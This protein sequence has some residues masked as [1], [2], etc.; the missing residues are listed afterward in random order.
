M[1]TRL[2]VP[3]DRFQRFEAALAYQSL[4][5]MRWLKALF[6]EWLRRTIDSPN[7]SATLKRRWRAFPE[8]WWALQREGWSVRAR[9][10]L[11]ASLPG[12]SQ[13][14]E[15]A[16]RLMVDR[17]LDTRDIPFPF[18]IFQ[19]NIGSVCK[20]LLHDPVVWEH[21]SR[22]ARTIA[23]CVRHAFIMLASCFWH[24]KDVANIQPLAVL[25]ARVRE[26]GNEAREALRVRRVRPEWVRLHQERQ[27]AE[28]QRDR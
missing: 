9:I 3:F 28:N 21:G 11:R 18:V 6:R 15:N 1:Q 27:T 22:T 14:N 26:A 2:T 16:I 19:S 5:R 7:R 10:Q 13:E 17:I 24:W 23:A 20:G 12:T 25:D 4:R 8:V